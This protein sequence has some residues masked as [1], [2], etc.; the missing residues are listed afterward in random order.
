[1]C[2]ALQ[3]QPVDKYLERLPHPGGKET[4]EMKRAKASDGG[5]AIEF[6]RFVQMTLDMVHHPVDTSCILSPRGLRSEYGHSCPL[7]AMAI[8]CFRLSEARKLPLREPPPPP[9]YTAPTPRPDH[10]RTRSSG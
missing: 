7:S 10:S 1:L 4:V 3:T 5:D 6:E 9:R 2:S 8:A